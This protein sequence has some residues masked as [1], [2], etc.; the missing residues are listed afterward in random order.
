MTMTLITQII[1][2]KKSEIFEKK[3]LLYCYD[4]YIIVL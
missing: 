2:R 4:Y 3:T 1:F